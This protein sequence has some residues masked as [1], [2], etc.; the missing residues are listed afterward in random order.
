MMYATGFLA[1][2]ITALAIR[3]ARLETKIETKDLL[4]Q[5]LQSDFKILALEQ[6]DIMALNKL[7]IERWEKAALDNTNLNHQNLNLLKRIQELES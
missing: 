5:T 3:N 4:I 7:C 1:V 2:V 6:K